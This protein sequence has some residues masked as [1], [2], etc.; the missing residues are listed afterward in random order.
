M[1]FTGQAGR[2]RHINLGNKQQKSKVDLLKKAEEDR[3]ARQQDRIRQN[4]ASVIQKQIRIRRSTSAERSQMLDKFLTQEYASINQMLADFVFAAPVLYRVSDAGPY[5][6]KARPGIESAPNFLRFQVFDALNSLFRMHNS[7]LAVLE[8]LVPLYQLPLPEST[9]STM[10]RFVDNTQGKALFSQVKNIMDSLATVYPQKVFDLLVTDKLLLEMDLDPK[11][12]L[13]CTLQVP[14]PPKEITTHLVEKFVEYPEASGLTAQLTS[15][16]PLSLEDS[17]VLKRL[18]TEKFFSQLVNS[19]LDVV[20]L[21]KFLLRVINS[22]FKSEV[23]LRLS[24]V[25]D[26]NLL[27]LLWLNFKNCLMFDTY[28][29]LASHHN[30]YRMLESD[31]WIV[32]WVILEM[33]SYWLVVCNDAEM[34]SNKIALDRDDVMLLARVLKGCVYIV[35]TAAQKAPTDF[36]SHGKIMLTTLRQIHIRDSRRQFFPTGFWVLPAQLPSRMLD[37]LSELSRKNIWELEDYDDEEEDRLN[38]SLPPAVQVLRQFPFFFEFTARVDLFNR[39][40]EDEK[41]SLVDFSML[42]KIEP[43]LIDRDAVVEDAFR[44]FMKLGRDLK[45]LLK[46]QFQSDGMV[47]SGIDG[48]GLTKEILTLTC[49][50]VFQEKNVFGDLFVE[51]VEHTVYPNPKYGEWPPKYDVDLVREQY[52]FLGRVLGKCL[53]ENVMVDV[54]FAPFFLQ[55]WA[56]SAGSKSSFDDFYLVDPEVYNSLVKLA[57]Y[58]GDVEEMGLDFTTTNARGAVVELKPHGQDIPVTNTNKFEYIHLLA[59]YHLNTVLAPQSRWFLQGMCDLISSEWLRMFSPKEIQILISGESQD[60]DVD[61]L[62]SHS[63]VNGF[64]HN[65]QTVSNFWEVVREMTPD[66]RRALLKFVTSV[67]R[68][69]LLGFKQLQPRFGIRF[70]GRNDSRLPTASTCVNLLKLPE[71]SSKEVLRQK[72]LYSIESESGFDLS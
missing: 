55:K 47:E 38:V 49:R 45:T 13:H 34:F 30:P 58:E 23:M 1:I 21:C 6:E 16:L 18:L 3:K 35:L 37:A 8:Q 17:A 46:V 31:D 15:T 29:D 64:A 60:F 33:Y 70:A 28:L 43:Q 53:Y 59:N 67:P 9:V 68:G 66:Q 72:L 19:N 48:G 12:F 26:S 36:V 63:E 62:Q 52:I 44:A 56:G 54:N 25:D 20:D 27:N 5:I 42:R 41:R 24:L 32:M 50:E 61:D 69:P 65:S 57:R 10:A 7:P 14:E 39:L 4:A 71:Y 22:P 11:H 40:I 2:K 51:T